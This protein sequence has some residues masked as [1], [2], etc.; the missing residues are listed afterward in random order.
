VNGKITMTPDPRF[1]P[2]QPIRTYG[3]AGY[4]VVAWASGANTGGKLIGGG[5]SDSAA[6]DYALMWGNITAVSRGGVGAVNWNAY[7]GVGY[8]EGM[9]LA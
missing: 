6:S 5:T 9:S 3:P 8:S 1:M 2:G 7:C 4:A